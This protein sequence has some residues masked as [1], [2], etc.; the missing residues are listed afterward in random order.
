MYFSVWPIW[1]DGFVAVACYSIVEGAK[2]TR[3]AHIGFAVFLQKNIDFSDCSI[4]ASFTY[5][6]D[7]FGLKYLNI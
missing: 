3:T 4:L 1:T 6:I 7:S 5:S 2:N